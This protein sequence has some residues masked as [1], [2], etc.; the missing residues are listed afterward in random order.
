MLLFISLKISANLVKC[1][2]DCQDLSSNMRRIASLFVGEILAK[3]FFHQVEVLFWRQRFSF[4]KDIY[5]LFYSSIDKIPFL[6]QISIQFEIKNFIE[7][8]EIEL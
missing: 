1:Q 6:T 4:T 8:D 7:K 5:R 2:K 3:Q